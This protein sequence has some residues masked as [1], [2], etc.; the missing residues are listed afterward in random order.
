MH[1]VMA[2]AGSGGG[3]G[4][5]AAA[6]GGGGAAEAKEEKKEEEEEEEDD[7]SPCFLP[8]LPSLCHHLVFA[9]N[10][11]HSLCRCSHPWPSFH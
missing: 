4:A 11:L 6:G 8:H 3:G 5:G 9:V 7:V 10:Q 1:E 2:V